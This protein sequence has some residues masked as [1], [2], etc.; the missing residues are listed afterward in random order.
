VA[1][2]ACDAR[3]QEFP[4]EAFNSPPARNAGEVFRDCE[5]CPQ[6]VVVP[7]GSFDMGSAVDDPGYH[8][9]EGPQHQVTI[10][11]AFAVGRFEVTVAQFRLFIEETDL[12]IAGCRVW[13][14]VGSGWIDDKARSWDDPLYVQNDN[15]PVVCVS[16]NDAQRYVEW[17]SQ[18]SG[19]TYRL[20]SEAEWEYAARAGSTTRY[21]WGNDASHSRMNFGADREMGGVA[22]GRD[23]W[24][25]AGP[26]GSFPPNQFGLYDMLGNV[27]EW[28]SDCRREDYSQ[29]PLDDAA[30]A[31]C[32]FDWR[33]VRGGSWLSGADITD[34]ANRFWNSARSR[35]SVQGFRVARDLD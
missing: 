10:S 3:E 13:L 4:S 5:G 32:R 34:S 28:V 15:Y 26:V 17:L 7:A 11:N 29:A 6:M 20:L 18:R 19:H 23:Q 21:Y 33:V 14:G 35:V 2:A 1:L 8:P 22:R 31:E 24:V 12:T 25:H 16:W 9:W 30:N 27:S